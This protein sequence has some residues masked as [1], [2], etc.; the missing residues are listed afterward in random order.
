MKIRHDK[1]DGPSRCF[2]RGLRALR[3][4]KGL[5]QKAL[6]IGVWGVEA[7]GDSRVSNIETHQNGA[8]LTTAY[9]L[10]KALGTTIDAVIAAGEKP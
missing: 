6:A 3:L 2:S 4:K 10:A 5:T 7:M 1:P 9:L 8:G